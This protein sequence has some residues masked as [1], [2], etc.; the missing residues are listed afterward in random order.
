MSRKYEI[1]DYLSD[2]L[3]SIEDIREFTSGMS[4]D[5]FA[6]D[7]KTVNAVIRSLEIICEASGKIPS[8]IREGHPYFPWCEVIGAGR[9]LVGEYH[10]VDLEIV[11]RTVQE[12]LAPLTRAIEKILLELA[13]SGAA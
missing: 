13:E 1:R 11:W 7:R 4:Y 2:I 5:D 9:K 10:G 6:A 3:V 8:E 12:E